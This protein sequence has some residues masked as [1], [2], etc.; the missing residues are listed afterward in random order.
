L[1]FTNNS[2]CFLPGEA[3]YIGHPLNAKPMKEWTVYRLSGEA[4][5]R[6][7]NEI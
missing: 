5:D 4:L 6:L 3:N 7:A 1:F 2:A